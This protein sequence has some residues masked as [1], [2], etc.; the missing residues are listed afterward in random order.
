MEATA[1]AGGEM[2][3]GD[4]C[5]TVKKDLVTYRDLIKLL[6]SHGWYFHREG[7]G[8]HMIYR[9]PQRPGII[10]IASGGKLGNEVPKGT[11]NAILR[12]A[13]LK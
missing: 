1:A 4:G 13:G 7:K 9:H 11:E 3:E 10:V 5:E 12:Q 2:L 6:Q 8:S